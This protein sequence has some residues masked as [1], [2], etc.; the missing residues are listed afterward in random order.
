MLLTLAIPSLLRASIRK[1]QP[2]TMNTNEIRD[3]Y[4]IHS[5]SLTFCFRAKATSMVGNTLNTVIEAIPPNRSRLKLKWLRQRTLPQIH[6][7]SVL[8]YVHLVDGEL[9]LCSNTPVLNTE[10]PVNNTRKRG[11]YKAS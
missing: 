3:K 2:I 5:S 6:K 9:D 1:Q 4:F 7:P 11:S 8:L 10:D